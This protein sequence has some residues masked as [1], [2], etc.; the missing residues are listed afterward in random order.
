MKSKEDQTRFVGYVHAPILVDPY[1]ACVLVQ[2]SA[3][4]V[5]SFNPCFLVTRQFGCLGKHDMSSRP[6]FEFVFGHKLFRLFRPTF[7]PRIH[8]PGA[9]PNFEPFEGSITPS[10]EVGAGL[11]DQVLVGRWFKNFHS[12]YMAL[13]HEVAA[14]RLSLPSLLVIVKRPK[15][16]SRPTSN[17]GFVAADA[18]VI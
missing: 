4:A 18:P 17:K 15:C 10:L 13:P 2:K 11:L 7:W 8:T 1:L 6:D 12:G 9:I 3:N 16:S 5:R 14:H